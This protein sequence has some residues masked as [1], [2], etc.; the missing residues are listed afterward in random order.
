M[1]VSGSAYADVIEIPVYVMGTSSSLVRRPRMKKTVP[2]SEPT[3]PVQLPPV[4]TEGVV[5]DVNMASLLKKQKKESGKDIRAS[6]KGVNL[7]AMEQ[8]ALNLATHDP[9]RLDTQIRSSISRLSVAW[10]SAAKML[11]LAAANHVKLVRQHDAEKAA[12]EDVDFALAGKYGEIAFPRDNASLVAEQ[13]P[14]PQ[15]IVHLR[16]KMNEMKK[17]LNRA[18][19][20]INRTQ[21]N[22]EKRV[23]LLEARLLDTQQCLQ[24]SQSRLKKKIMP[25][26]G[27]RAADTDHE[28]QMADV[29]AFYGAEL[30]RVKNKFRRYISSC[31]KDV[32]VENDKVENKWFAKRDEGGGALT[33]KPRAEDSEEEEVEDLLPHTRHKTRPQEVEGKENDNVAAL[34]AL[35]KK[36]S[37]KLQ[38]CSLAV[39]RKTLLNLKMESKMLEL[40]SR[41]NVVTVELPCK[42]AKILTAN[43]ESEQ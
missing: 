26:W 7:K 13:T 43:N 21:Q 4:G 32:E 30:E 14:T 8:E 10:K 38:Q 12:L 18:R 39:E 3:A 15:E 31:G 19:D 17:A 9:I 24:V 28:R 41:L 2:P 22:S 29:I 27:K 6:S 34:S 35:N 1:A 37:A 33:S 42:D 25:K 5:V 11:K 20:F 40:Q 23:T 36:L 16:E